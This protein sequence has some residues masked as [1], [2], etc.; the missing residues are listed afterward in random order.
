MDEMYGGYVEKLNFLK[1][2]G[3]T[4]QREQWIPDANRKDYLT[5]VVVYGSEPSS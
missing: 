3:L 5:P 2:D 1:G 4:N